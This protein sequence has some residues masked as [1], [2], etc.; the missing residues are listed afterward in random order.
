MS[1]LRSR[2]LIAVVALSASLSVSAETI[3]GRVVAVS[4]GDTL[5]ILDVD[6][7]GFVIRGVGPYLSLEVARRYQ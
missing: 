6:T 7:L 2:A 5:T 3:C 1:I 4:D